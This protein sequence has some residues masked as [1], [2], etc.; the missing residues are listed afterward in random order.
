MILATANDFLSLSWK[1]FQLTPV[2]YQ[3]LLET[4]SSDTSVLS[5]DK[6]HFHLSDYVNKHSFLYWAETNPRHFLH[7]ERATV[8]CAVTEFGIIGPYLF[9]EDGRTVAGTSACYI[10]ILH[11]FLHPKLNEVGNPVGGATAHTAWSSMNLLREMCAVHLILRG[12]I[13]WWARSLDL[14]HFDFYLWGYL[15]APIYQHKP[16]TMDEL[17][18]AIHR[19]IAENRT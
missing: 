13:Q 10:Q 7:T 8:W 15:K 2:Y 6:V 19:E 3:A 5:S 4:I 16:R 17:K 1:Q 9:E 12:D 11:K 18:V 14:A